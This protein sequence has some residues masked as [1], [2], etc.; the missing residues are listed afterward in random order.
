MDNLEIS[1]DEM[2][3]DNNVLWFC[4]TEV[5]GLFRIDLETGITSVECFFP[6]DNKYAKKL[7]S[8]IVVH[9]DNVFAAP[10]NG[11]CIWRYNKKEKQFYGLKLQNLEENG[12]YIYNALKK[13][14]KYKDSIYFFPGRYSSI[15]KVDLNNYK[16]DY[17]DDWKIKNI[18]EGDQNRVVFNNIHFNSVQGLCVLPSWRG[19]G[20]LL[21]DLEMNMFRQM[22]QLFSVDEIMDCVSIGNDSYAFTKKNSNIFSTLGEKSAKTKVGE[23]DERFYFVV[24]GEEC[25]LVPQVGNRIIVVD[26]NTGENRSIYTA[27]IDENI[28]NSLFPAFV[29]EGEAVYIF[30]YYEQ[31]LLIVNSNTWKVRELEL[32][33]DEETK[34][35]LQIRKELWLSK[36]IYFENKEYSIANLID[37]LKEI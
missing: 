15:V 35:K 8:G 7:Y 29:V 37:E 10:C 32:R 13:A 21:F 14:G 1:F 4:G 36:N 6:D 3:K 5:S 30:S 25:L 11:Y 26:S 24:A 17:L 16:V 22:D 23:V 19:S 20:G 2:T 18:V 27:N 9:E 31:K 33:Y 12:E 34:M 28:K